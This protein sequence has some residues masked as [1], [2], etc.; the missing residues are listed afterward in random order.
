MN[1]QSTSAARWGGVVWA[2]TLLKQYSKITG[3]E[4]EIYFIEYVAA[5]AVKS[6]QSC[7]TLSGP[8]DS[9]PPGSKPV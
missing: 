7:P 1:M 8:I 5:A 4:E 9:S 6:R 2:N 3:G